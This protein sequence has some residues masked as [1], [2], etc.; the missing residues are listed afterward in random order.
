[1]NIVSLDQ[2]NQFVLRKQYL[3]NKADNV[4]IVRVV[5]SICGLH[6]TSATTPYLSLFSRVR[7]FK[8]KTLDEELYQ[9]KNLGKIRC[10]RKTVFVLSKD[11]IPI[12]FAAT[13]K[14][15]EPVSEKYSKYLSISKD[16]YEETSKAIRSLLYKRGMTALEIKKT[17]GRKKSVSPI[18]NLMC[19]QGLLIR[20]P[21]RKD[22]KSS[23][24]T[25]LLFNEY[26]PDMDL[27]SIRASDAQALI[28]GKYLTSF[29]PVTEEDI[30][31]WTG[32][33]KRQIQQ[34]L[35]KIYDTVFQLRIK[36]INRKYL[37]LRS[38]EELLKNEG[39]L[40]DPLIN[41]LPSLDPY[42]MG[43]KNRERYL[44]PKR[45]YYVFDRS[46]NSTSTILLNGRVI[47]IWDFEDPLIKIFLFDKVQT[48]ILEEICRKAIELGSFISGKEAQLKE[49]S[50]MTHL[51]KRR[52]GGFMTPLKNC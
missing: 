33:P 25:Y 43:Y 50:S 34:I 28:V 26:F 38:E 11:V 18:V 7:N 44:E 22:W 10:I 20:G 19:D 17:L 52:V 29:G 42:I 15:V 47:G 39:S 12:A 49:C 27:A 48:K 30:T 14:M 32:F 51:L 21:P 35:K 3:I 1:M 9:K 36:G 40:N 6:A 5:R 24:H 8:K 45:Y 2:V 23:T 4:S 46:G 31:W 41:L 13:N 16:E 37:M